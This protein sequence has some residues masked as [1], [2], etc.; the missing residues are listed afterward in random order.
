MRVGIADA[1]SGESFA[2][3]LFPGTSCPV[4]ALF[5]AP[6]HRWFRQNPDFE[7][8]ERV[9]FSGRC[10]PVKRAEAAPPDRSCPDLPSS[11]LT[12]VEGLL[13]APRN[14][15]VL[16]ADNNLETLMRQD[17]SAELPSVDAAPDWA[18]YAS[19]RSLAFAMLLPLGLR[20]ED[21]EDLLQEVLL[22]GLLRRDR[23]RS[24]IRWFVVKLRRDAWRL[25]AKN[26]RCFPLPTNEL[27]GLVDRQFG[28]QA[29]LSRLEVDRILARLPPRRALLLGLIY[30]KGLSDS[31]T[32]AALGLSPNSIK[33]LRTRA[34]AA[35]RRLHTAEEYTST[36][37]RL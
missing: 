33:R 31:E 32:A 25:V 8:P 30:F 22:A 5:R 9:T 6:L 3:P 16:S 24:P 15:W 27:A 35:A 28:F 7:A 36:P 1:A 2:S 37:P 11:C 17:S 18:D 26:R 12:R 29:P 14:T 13:A 23:I 19:F 34:L 21:C 10:A 4:D 20:H